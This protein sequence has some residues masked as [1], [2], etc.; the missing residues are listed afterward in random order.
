[1]VTRKGMSAF[2]AMVDAGLADERDGLD[3]VP[4]P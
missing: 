1:M 2:G 4:S 3:V